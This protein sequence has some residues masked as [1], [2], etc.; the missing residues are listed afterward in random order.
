M[1]SCW[2][3]HH[4]FRMCWSAAYIC[5]GK[6][7][8]EKSTL[9]GC[10]SHDKSTFYVGCSDQHLMRMM[11]NQK[12]LDLICLDMGG[13]QVWV[14]EWVSECE[15]VG[16]LVELLNLPNWLVT[17]LSPAISD[18][19]KQNVPVFFFSLFKKNLNRQQHQVLYCV[20][21]RAPSCSSVTFWCCCC[22]LC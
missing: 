15:C 4:G 11:L 2:S 12:V 5:E 9:C 21:K 7:F 17:G 19:E 22:T 10:V 20:T 16:Q 1:S 18:L 8:Y 13:F 14:S 6:A 3:S